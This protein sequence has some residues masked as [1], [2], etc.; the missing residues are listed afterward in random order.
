MMNK[1]I[2][3]MVAFNEWYKVD[4]LG[5]LVK[6][7]GKTVYGPEHQRRDNEIKRYLEEHKPELLQWANEN[8]LYSEDED[9]LLREV[10]SRK[11]LIEAVKKHYNNILNEKD[12]IIPDMYCHYDLTV[13]KVPFEGKFKSNDF[14]QWEKEYV[15]LKKGDYLASEKNPLIAI[16]HWCG[17]VSV[18][19]LCDAEQPK[20]DWVHST[21]TAKETENNVSE[22]ALVFK[23]SKALWTEK[24]D[25]PFK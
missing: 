12:I 13:K 6:H 22:M 5:N 3:M 11:L 18:Y 25:M 21:T 20:T 9:F 19:R 24:I 8:G 15:S 17:T 2:L 16:P 10:L 1:T 4:E 23:R 7:N 14:D